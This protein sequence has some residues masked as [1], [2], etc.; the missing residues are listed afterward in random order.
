MAAKKANKAGEKLKSN[1]KEL[2]SE[3]K[4]KALAI[5]GEFIQEQAGNIVQMLK[6]M[7][8]IKKMIKKFLISAI[9]GL[10]ATTLL[11]FGIAGVLAMYFTNVAAVWWQ[12]IV[13]LAT[14]LVI[15]LY[16]KS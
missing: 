1:L 9:A 13:A 4:D 7:L 16:M 8:K 14:L 11:L 3:Y 5:F 10:A 12:V 2:Y 6:D 15:S